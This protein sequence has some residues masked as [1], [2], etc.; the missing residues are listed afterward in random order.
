VFQE[1]EAGTLRY[2]QLDHVSGHN[3]G[4][5]PNAT[6]GMLLSKAIVKASDLIPH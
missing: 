2:I 1:Y 5:G 6:T 4:D 3:V